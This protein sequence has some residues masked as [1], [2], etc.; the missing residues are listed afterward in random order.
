MKRLPLDVLRLILNP[1]DD[2]SHSDRRAAAH[3]CPMMR[4]AVDVSAARDRQRRALDAALSSCAA[5]VASVRWRSSGSSVPV[6]L[7]VHGDGALW[8]ACTDRRTKLRVAYSDQATASDVARSAAVRRSIDAA[9]PPSDPTEHCD[10]DDDDD[11][12]S[13][14]GDDGISL[15]HPSFD[16]GVRR[17]FGGVADQPPAKRVRRHMVEM[18]ILP[19]YDGDSPADAELVYSYID[20]AVRIAV[21]ERHRCAAVARVVA[22]LKRAYV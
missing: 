14:A 3:A 8:I 4:A 11:D 16:A 9:P 20:A 19:C 1:Y 10:S 6:E 22:Q 18:H 7:V 15:P 12:H 13:A 21:P 5:L 2:V 17:M